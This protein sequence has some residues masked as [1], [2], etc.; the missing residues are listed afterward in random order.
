MSQRSLSNCVSVLVSAVF[1]LGVS[2]CGS[3]QK[4]PDA[5]AAPTQ[6]E[7]APSKKALTYPEIVEKYSLMELND[8]ATAMRVVFDE[9]LKKGPKEQVLDCEIAGEQAQ[10]YM[11]PLKSLIDTQTSK[12]REEY[13]NDPGGY[14]KAKGFDTCGARCACG[15]LAG[16]LEGV[17][18]SELSSPAAKDNHGKYLSRLRTKAKLQSPRES[19]ACAQRQNWFCNSPLRTYIDRESGGF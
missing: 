1:L 5:A 11:M 7:A 12:E 16:V 8:A 9:S 14:A 6:E 17:S 4:N 3:G 13:I 2:A 15:A 10:G 19:L 18:R